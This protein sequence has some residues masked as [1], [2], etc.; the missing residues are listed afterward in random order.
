MTVV[1]PVGAVIVGFPSTPQIKISQSPE[2]VPLG[3]LID[4]LVAFAASVA[5]VELA[6][7]GTAMSPFQKKGGVFLPASFPH[8]LHAVKR[9]NGARPPC[10]LFFAFFLGILDRLDY[11]DQFA[12]IHAGRRLKTKLTGELEQIRLCQ[13]R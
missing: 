4:L 5:V 9:Q 10:R 3:L 12:L 1:K 6:I 7:E 13:R 11:L 2:A 8:P